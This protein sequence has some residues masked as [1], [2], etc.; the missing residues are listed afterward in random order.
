MIVFEEKHKQQNSV[1][2]HSI[3]TQV[4]IHVALNKV[5]DSAVIWR[6]W[7]QLG[8]GKVKSTLNKKK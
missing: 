2:S 4:L 5:L 8:R 7:L 6:L 3:P 1:V